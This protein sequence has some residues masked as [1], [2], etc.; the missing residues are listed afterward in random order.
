MGLAASERLTSSVSAELKIRLLIEL[1][2]AEQCGGEPQ[3][4]TDHIQAG[5]DALQTHLAEIA[6]LAPAIQ[7]ECYQLLGELYRRKGKTQQHAQTFLEQALAIYRQEADQDAYTAKIAETLYHLADVYRFIPTSAQTDKPDEKG[8]NAL[9]DSLELARNIQDWHLQ[10]RCLS[11]LARKYERIDFPRAREFALQALQVADTLNP[12]NYYITVQALDT[13]ARV[14]DG[15][16]SYRTGIQY[17]KKARALTQQTGD[18]VAE[19]GIL[20]LLGE[21]YSWYVTLQAEAQDILERCIKTRERIGLI[22]TNALL[23][24]GVVAGQQGQWQTAEQY[25]RQTLD[26]STE[27]G[28]AFSRYHLGEVFLMQERYQEAQAE[29]AESL[30]ILE[31]YQSSLYLD[32]YAQVVLTDA[33]AHDKISYQRHLEQAQAL[34]ACETRPYDQFVYRFTMAEVH[35]LAGD[36]K[37]ARALCHAAV[38]AEFLSQIEDADLLTCI[39]KARL[40]M[41]KILVDLAEYEQATSYLSQARNAFET[42]GHYALGETLLYLGKAYYGPGGVVFGHQARPFIEQA[43]AE[44]QRLEL[45]RKECEAQHVMQALTETA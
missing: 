14:C 32:E 3:E 25:F 39:A 31:K 34:F 33:L 37:A 41:G 28:Q 20:Y 44:F 38:S 19:T 21:K 13:M 27:R 45:A 15:T 43:L 23:V 12:P 5:I 35:R 22:K 10:S 29:F 36:L 26:Q 11:L 8:L 40:V 1:A 16:L 30:R 6:T 17:L 7:A 18:I 4:N 24:L 9:T 42:C 2:K